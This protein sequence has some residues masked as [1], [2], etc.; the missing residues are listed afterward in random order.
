MIERRHIGTVMQQ[1]GGMGDHPALRTSVRRGSA[2]RSALLW[3]ILLLFSAT[4]ALAQSTLP[5]TTIR[6]T[7]Q[8]QYGVLG[9]TR[10]VASSEAAVVV[11]PAPTRAQVS[12][13]RLAVSADAGSASALAS[14]GPTQ[15]RTP[16]GFVVLPAPVVA[17]N[18]ALDVGAPQPL[19]T[20]AVSHAGDAAFLRVSDGDQN[21]DG[22]LRES[23]D[24]R[25]TARSSGDVEIVR[26]L[27]TG[28]DTGVFVGYVPTA[29]G[30][31]S[32]GDCVLQ[33]ARDSLID[34]S[35]VDTHDATD[36]ATAT[37]LVDPSGVVFDSSTGQPVDGARV[38]LLDSASGAAA[39]VLGDDGVSRFPAEMLTGA[40][41]TDSGGTVYRFPAGVFRFPLV[42]PGRYRLLIEPPT[43]YQFAS[44]LAIADLQTLPGAPFRLG[45]GSFGRDFDVT[46]P[47]GTAVDVPLDAAGT[48]LVLRKTAGSAQAAVGDVVEY[49]L[50]LQNASP[51]GAL[52]AIRISDILP[53]GMSYRRGSTRRDGAN[54]A[55]PV[56]SSDSR[57]LQYD[58][59]L[60]SAGQSTEI[61]YVAEVTVAAQRGNLVNVASA[62]A[63]NGVASN[64]ARASVL[65][66]QSLF[67]GNGFMAGRVFSGACSADDP[68]A[69]AA[70]NV[71]IYLEDGRYAVTDAGGRYHFEDVAPGTHVAQLD[72]LTL[73]EHLQ[74][75][76][77]G[78]D[79]RRAG[80]RHSQFVELRAG[81]LVRA[82]FALEQRPAPTGS[83]TL[84]VQ[85]LTATGESGYEFVAQAQN[86]AASDARLLIMLP[87]N[88]TAR[89]LTIDGTA[90]PSPTAQGGVMSIPLGE[91]PA[92]VTRRVVLSLAGQ[93][94]PPRAVLTFT[95]KDGTTL[96]TEPLAAGGA[97]V[98]ARVATRGAWAQPATPANDAHTPGHRIAPDTLNAE[99]AAIDV[100]AVTAS[101]AWLTPRVDA[102]PA[103]A[104][105]KIAISHAPQQ[106]VE[107]SVNGEA[108]SR[109]NFDGVQVN[110]ARSAAVSR[111]RGVDLR[112]GDNQLS[113]RV[114]GTD[115]AVVAT[116][117]RVVHYGG[118]AVRAEIDRTRSVLTADG[119][120]RPVVAIRL[121]DAY[122]KPARRGTLGAFRVDPPY[123][124]WWEVQANDDNPLLT[125]GS[126]EPTFEVGD[127]GLALVELEPTTQAGYA[128]AHLRFS[129]RRQQELRVWLAPATRDWILVGLASGTVARIKADAATEP[130]PQSMQD[131]PPLSADDAATGGRVALFAKGRVR[132][133]FLLTLAY[134]SARDPVAA[135]RR[136]QGVIEPDRYYLL[137]GD[138]VAQRNEAPSSEKLF[139]RLERREF[140]AL[141]GDYDTGFT[142]TE[143]TRYSRSLTGLKADFGGQAVGASAFAAKTDNG[144]A[145]DEL[146]GD[147]TS[148]PYRLSRGDIIIGSDKLRIEVRDRFRIDQIISTREL[149]RFIDYDIDYTLGTVRLREP[150]SDRDGQFNPQF[151]IADYETNGNGQQHT[152]AGART[153]AR[154][155]GGALEAGATAVLDGAQTG[156]TKVGGLDLR[157][158]LTPVTELRAEVAH[159]ESDDPARAAASTA[160]LTEVQHVSEHLEAKAWARSE[161][162]GFGSRQTLSADAGMR[163][164]GFDARWKFNEQWSLQSNAEA[165]D[166]LSTDSQRRLAGTELRYQGTRGNAAVGVRHIDDIVAANGTRTSDLLTASGSRELLDRRLTLRG[167]VDSAL[168]GQDSSIDYPSRML[169]GADWR[170]QPNTTLFTEWEHADGANIRSDMTRIGVRAQPWERTQITSSV[171]QD[172]TEFGP[173]RFANFG[174]TQRLQLDPHW[175]MDLGLDQT[176]SLFSGSGRTDALALPQPLASGSTDE[177][178]FAT[179]AGAQ[180]HAERWTFTSRVERRVADLG[181]R[182]TFSSGWYREPVAGQALSL[183]ASWQNETPVAAASSALADVRFAWAWRPDDSPWIILDRTELQYEKHGD[184]GIGAAQVLGSEA[185]RLIQNLN[186]NL[187]FDE[188]TQLG[189]Q[190]GLRYALTTLSDERFRGLATLAGFDLRRDLTPKLFGRA[191]DVGLHGSWLGSHEV[192][193]SDVS[194]GADVGITLITNLWV[195]LGYNWEGF[196]ADEFASNR[197][198][199]GGVYLKF[200][201]KAD[202]D[203]FKD[204]RLDS[205]RPAR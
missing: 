78:S 183:A 4:A 165:Q 85:P 29:V 37:S 14:V 121:F 132:G 99:A 162:A 12:V 6:N 204:L 193:T 103:I 52:R 198:T 148:G 19:I 115:G 109:L 48:E 133:D 201:F 15:C 74:L 138:G 8:V 203:T 60:L 100:E 130:L 63:D 7:A 157:W 113:A 35:Y 134:D 140:V 146:R 42:A 166:S 185:T 39:N 179:F 90:A 30:A 23:V 34:A 161:A 57:T 160:W 95:A 67:T 106:H 153:T 94:A 73:P 79:S 75:A 124:S 118:G 49:R 202:Q 44:T 64:E 182:L 184:F 21:R 116:L 135:R 13:A 142:A 136:L 20:T 3:P 97:E 145:H 68:V 111:W 56:I 98:A 126:R 92:T 31:A 192:G 58:V 91:L 149:A 173:R 171:S 175:S 93:A 17:G 141:F 196:R 117:Q 143:L 80:R 112:D 163:R 10:S 32:S 122:G 123:R 24:L 50:T 129:E 55:D 18:T 40:A 152:V 180:Y 127:D 137:Y 9:L 82:D 25:V 27:E 33:V 178:Y 191:L 69:V 86:L 65:L 119:R 205:L 197:Q 154:L 76:A 84:S 186:G 176:R 43:G 101:P 22:T 1:Q 81:A 156:D 53:R 187:Q 26:L 28:P 188:R 168:G 72:T 96:R 167:S 46:A 169:L 177:N 200:R 70:A 38:R 54:V 174:L 114:L 47:A 170:L 2:L 108:V 61:R 110:K 189:L 5:G 71:R 45:D 164:Y 158:H 190:L 89:A 159:S 155:A 105:L 41:A 172:S 181:N 131:E 151:I 199:A 104:S 88:T 83:V 87:A 195:S 16:S 102:T 144:Q 150:L 77:C 125:Q 147:G 107:L 128:V 194:Y 51:H 120:T 36:T 139:V 59:D 62:R 66:Q 11:E